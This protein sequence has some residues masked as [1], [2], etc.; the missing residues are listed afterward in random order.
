[1]YVAVHK[2]VTVRIF[3]CW[4]M[5]APAAAYNDIWN[6]LVDFSTFYPARPS[7]LG[8]PGLGQARPAQSASTFIFER[9]V[10]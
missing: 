2:R 10:Y 6:M 9:A 7:V 3:K 5:R 4:E 1:M 8:R